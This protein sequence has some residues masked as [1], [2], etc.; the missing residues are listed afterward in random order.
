VGEIETMN[1]RRN[2]TVFT[3]VSEGLVRLTVLALVAGAGMKLI[4][5]L[6]FSSSQMIG[7]SLGSL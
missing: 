4:E 5:N 7:T 3:L 1:R 6:Q 2:A